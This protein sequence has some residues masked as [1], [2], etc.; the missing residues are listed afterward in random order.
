[1]VPNEYHLSFH[2]RPHG[3]NPKN[4][5]GSP[6]IKIP[7]YAPTKTAKRGKVAVFGRRRENRPH[8]KPQDAR[9]GG[10]A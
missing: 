4:A 9:N 8:R 7:S 10:E 3:E 2:P 5:P 6:R 1:M